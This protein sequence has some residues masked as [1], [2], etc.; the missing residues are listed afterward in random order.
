MP[1]TLTQYATIPKAAITYPVTPNMTDY[2]QVRAAF[3][4][5]RA[6]AD[7]LRQAED[8]NLARLAVEQHALGPGRDRVALRWLGR[9]GEQRDLCYGELADLSS[10]FANTLQGLGIGAGD[11]VV[12]ILGRV[13]ELYVAAL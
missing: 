13:P 4:W 9:H 6:R 10:R 12:A 8:L 7:V 3:D 5:Q 1:T 11:T 2:E